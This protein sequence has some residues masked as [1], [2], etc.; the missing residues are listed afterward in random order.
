VAGGEIAATFARAGDLE[1]AKEHAVATAARAATAATTS[2]P[3]RKRLCDAD[4]L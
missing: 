3:K 1:A 4:T 2:A